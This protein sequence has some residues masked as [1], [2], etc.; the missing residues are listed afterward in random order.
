MGRNDFAFNKTRWHDVKLTRVMWDNL[1]DY[2][3]GCPLGFDLFWSSFYNVFFP[4][5]V[6]FFY[7]KESYL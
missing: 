1:I 6:Q 4:F 2:G 7:L 3:V 5:V